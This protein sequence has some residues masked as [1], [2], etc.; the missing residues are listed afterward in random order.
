MKSASLILALPTLGLAFPSFLGAENTDQILD[1]LR[2]QKRTE[3]QAP[4][5]EKRQGLV[6]SLLGDVGGLLGSVAASVDPS[7]KRPEP[8]YEFQAP[9]PNDSRGPCPGL[10]LLANYG[11]LPRDG[12]VNF[13]QVLSASLKAILTLSLN[14]PSLGLQLSLSS[15][16]NWSTSIISPPIMLNG[17]TSPRNPIPTSPK[18]LGSMC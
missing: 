3:A 4:K 9:G 13:G 1:N 11:Y 14:T 7:N 12:Y 17:M 16:I 10:N 6:S 15:L 18:G 8:G 2:E 5:P